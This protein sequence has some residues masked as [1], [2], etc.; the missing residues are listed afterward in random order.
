MTP[1]FRCLLI[2]SYLWRPPTVVGGSLGDHQVAWCMLSCCVCPRSP[3]GLWDACHSLS[4]WLASTCPVLSRVV[5]SGP[6]SLMGTGA[7]GPF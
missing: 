4:S 7:G 6:R 2:G 5:L 3:W 1:W